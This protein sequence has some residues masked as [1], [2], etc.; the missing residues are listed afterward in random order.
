M[1]HICQMCDLGR[2]TCSCRPAPPIPPPPRLFAT[3]PADYLRDQYDPRDFTK[4]SR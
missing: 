2:E 3:R 1:N 4:E